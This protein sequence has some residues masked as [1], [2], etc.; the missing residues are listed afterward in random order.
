[1][2]ATTFG[3]EL[4]P[5]AKQI[6]E[7][8]GIDSKDFR[9]TST[10]STGSGGFIID[11]DHKTKILA[12]EIGDGVLRIKYVMG[13]TYAIAEITTS[14]PKKTGKLLREKL[15]CDDEVEIVDPKKVSVKL[16]RWWRKNNFG[17]LISLAVWMVVVLVVFTPAINFIMAAGG[18]AL[19][20]IGH[21]T[22][23]MT[24]C[25]TGG[26]LTVCG[27]ALGFINLRRKKS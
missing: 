18:L 10:G 13:T 24:G 9:A 17:T 16:D 22:G 6:V 23:S 5:F 4:K 11:Y 20:L 27:L 26:I 8:L 2:E 15:P 12:M 25:I 1:M 19:A 21:Q 14:N 7:V 3:S